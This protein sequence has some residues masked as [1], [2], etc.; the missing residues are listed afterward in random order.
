MTFQR[1]L[2]SFGEAADPTIGSWIFPFAG[3]GQKSATEAVLGEV[4]SGI[5]TACQVST[6]R[7]VQDEVLVF[8][9][10]ANASVDEVPLSVG[11]VELGVAVVAMLTAERPRHRRMLIHTRPAPPFRPLCC[12]QQDPRKIWD[13]CS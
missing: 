9:A 12:R 4:V 11:V 6:A 13:F 8:P 3:L 10:L 7:H 5:R 1:T 2:S